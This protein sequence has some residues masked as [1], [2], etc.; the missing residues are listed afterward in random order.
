MAPKFKIKILGRNFQYDQALEIIQD[1]EYL[2]DADFDDIKRNYILK[3]IGEFNPEFN[4]PTSHQHSKW[5]LKH[6]K[7][8]K[9]HAL[10]YNGKYS[11]HHYDYNQRQL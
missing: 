5:M 11:K 6:A 10:Q 9:Q 1:E 4:I 7:I 2:E 8:H 3:K